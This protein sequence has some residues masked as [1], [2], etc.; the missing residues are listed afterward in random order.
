MYCRT[1]DGL[2]LYYD[3]KGNPA[4][5][6]TIVFLNGL[7]QSTLAWGFLVPHFATDYRI[8]L[9]DQVFQGQSSKEGGW[10]DFD[11]HARD[12]MTVLEKEKCPPVN[13]VGLSYGSLVAQHFALLFPSKV[14]KLVL[15][16]TFAA[17]TP[18]SEAIEQ[19]WWR[20]LEQG[21]YD[22]MFDVMLP[23]V[24]SED[25]FTNPV[26]PIEAMKEMR[27]Q[28]N[29]NKDAILKLMTA[30]RA[31]GDYRQNLTRISS[32][33]LVIQGEK[34]LLLP[35]HMAREVQKSIPGAKLVVIKNAGHTLNL[36]HTGEVAAAIRAFL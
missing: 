27:K 23:T 13:L 20:A 33:T 31:R 10:R 16:S 28:A 11:R 15:I 30:T 17:K 22:L 29:Q 19:A 21:G 36:E 5:G 2:E 14:K 9:L 25:Y 18:Y 35:V 32:P 4:A 3:I 6:E 8:I 1:D 34:D 7:T 12:V 26:V 24:L